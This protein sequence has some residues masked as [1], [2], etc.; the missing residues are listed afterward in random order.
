MKPNYKII[1]QTQESTCGM[2]VLAMI[3]NKPEQYVLDWF[4]YI[5]PPIGDED[6]FIFLAHHGKYLATCGML[7][8]QKTNKGVDI[9]KID[10]ISVEWPMISES[11]M[12]VDSETREDW[13]HAVFWT[14]K[15][16][17]DP[18]HKTPQ[19]LSNYKVRYIY[20]IMHSIKPLIKKIGVL[21]NG[22]I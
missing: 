16:V 13:S 6:A 14:G 15:E 19:P 20:P 12:V 11:Y 8:N 18:L 22:R 5:D 2:C 3:V 21:A 10:I 4:K 7:K 9:S 1:N 17:F